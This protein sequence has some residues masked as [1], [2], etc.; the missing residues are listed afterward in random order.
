MSNQQPVPVTVMIMDKEYRVACPPDER[1]ALLASASLLNERMREIRDS[2][3]VIGAERIGVMAALNIAHEL[4][5]Q[6]HAPGGDEHP[7][8]SRIRAMQ[9][10]IESALNE[11]KQ[12]E[13]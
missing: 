2:G 3:K 9:H 8:R 11:G 13:L 6:K 1:D 7:A 4:V 12:L 5:L 10:K